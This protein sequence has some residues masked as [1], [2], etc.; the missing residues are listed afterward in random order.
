VTGNV[1]DRS[2]MHQYVHLI[3][4]PHDPERR[5]R[6]ERRSLDPESSTSWRR[7]G[8]EEQWRD[9]IRAHLADGEPRTFNRIAVELADMTADVATSGPADP[10]LWSLVRD[11]EVEHTTEAPI[12]FRRRAA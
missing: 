9:R 8:T 2:G 10:A 1:V 5:S 12:Y 7:M 4:A 3:R 11:G 6:E